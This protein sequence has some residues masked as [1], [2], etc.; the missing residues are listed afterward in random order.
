M[1]GGILTNIFLGG[2][3]FIVFLWVE[4]SCW[5]LVATYQN[6]STPLRILFIVTGPKSKYCGVLSIISSN[7]LVSMRPT[8][9]DSDSTQSGG[10]FCLLLARSNYLKNTPYLHRY[11]A[12]RTSCIIVHYGCPL[13]HQFT[14]IVSLFESSSVV[15]RDRH[16]AQQTR[17]IFTPCNTETSICAYVCV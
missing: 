15:Y 8:R 16:G 4:L 11:G 7:Q 14:R 2:S 17:S 3:I 13:I 1:R 6:N 12:Y 5:L 10:N 9:I